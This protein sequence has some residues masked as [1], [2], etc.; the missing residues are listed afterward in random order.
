VGAVPLAAEM[1]S[2]APPSAVLKDAVQERVPAPAL[3]IS[4]GC[5]GGAL[6]LVTIE[7]LS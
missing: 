1:A 4:N 3:R 6:P 5:A 7:K 2:Q